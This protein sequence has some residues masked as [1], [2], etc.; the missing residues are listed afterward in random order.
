MKRND[1]KLGWTRLI[2]LL[3]KTDVEPN[4]T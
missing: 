2:N 1:I 3:K 4:G